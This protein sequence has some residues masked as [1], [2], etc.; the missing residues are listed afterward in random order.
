M[1]RRWIATTLL[2]LAL[3]AACGGSADDDPADDLIGS[4]GDATDVERMIENGVY[5]FLVGE[6][7]MRSEEP[8]ARLRELFF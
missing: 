5:C 7:F 1:Q 2:S 6:A 4:A 8:G 3:L